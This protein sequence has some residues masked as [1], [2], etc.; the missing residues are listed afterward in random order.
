LALEMACRHGLTVTLDPG[1]SVPQAALDEMRALLPAIDVLLPSL[2]EAQRLTGLVKPELC[3]QSLLDA[4][5]TVVALKLGGEGCLIGS[6]LG[7]SRVPG[8]SVHARDTTGAGDY[9]AAGLIA[10]FLG[11]L[12]WLDAAVLANAMGAVAVAR[13]GA[14]TSVPK[15]GE[16]LDLLRVHRQ[17]SDHAPW[18]DAIQRVS[19]FVSSLAAESKEEG[20]RWWK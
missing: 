11:G 2:A 7:L 20:K 12:D 5:V 4:G 10:A 3:A 19:A 17:A 9:F 6:S 15:A 13:V 8:F 1:M 14:G 16:V 18:A